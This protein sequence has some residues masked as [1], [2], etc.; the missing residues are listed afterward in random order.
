MMGLLLR[1]FARAMPSLGVKGKNANVSRAKH[2]V[3][4]RVW[5]FEAGQV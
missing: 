3:I 2:L 4:R 5:T 1:V